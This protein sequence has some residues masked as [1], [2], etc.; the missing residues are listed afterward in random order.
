[1]SNSTKIPMGASFSTHTTELAPTQTPQGVTQPKGNA[2]PPPGD[3]V[4]DVRGVAKTYR[5]ARSA[6][7]HTTLS[8][9]AVARLRRFGRGAPRDEFD[10]LDDVSLKIY[11]GESV[12]LIGRNGAGKSTLLKLLTRITSP[13]RGSIDIRGRVGSLLEV[14]TGFHPELTGRENI[15][16]NG[17]I[18]GMRKVEIDRSFDQ[19]V[20]FS[21]VGGFL[22]TPVKRY[23]SGM[24]VRLAFAV[25][26]NLPSE[27]L[28]IDEVLSVGDADFRSR[29]IER[30]RYLA[31]EG[32]TVLFVSH[33]LPS[34]LQLC[35]RAV[36]LNKGTV[37]FDGNADDAAEFYAR[38]NAAVTL[39]SQEDRSRRPGS[40]AVRL[41]SFL[42]TKAVFESDDVKEFRY[43][44]ES[45]TTHSER[46]SIE[47]VIFGP[48]GD[49]VLHC[50]SHLLGVSLDTARNTSGTF[51]IT[52]PWLGPGQYSVSVGLRG[53]ELFDDAV[54]A[55][56]F[57]VASGLPYPVP[58]DGWSAMAPILA[59]FEW[60]VE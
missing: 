4:I 28:L 7:R 10:A 8:E 41:M 33:H 9:A 56:Q 37:A 52:S 40:G 57:E 44:V 48:N 20:E 32:R 24:Y 55:C 27:I 15:Y 31:S 23:S 1:M 53:A 60:T 46:F 12:G 54:G 13:S 36:V 22:D 5:I 51:R 25:A 49:M 34:V 14:G 21:G 35:G 39:H 59:D 42:P 50:H 18:L 47:A 16:L 30:M 45:M 58:N 3:L 11:Q 29:S 17:S 26:S 38:S 2:A 6:D 43:V 19:I